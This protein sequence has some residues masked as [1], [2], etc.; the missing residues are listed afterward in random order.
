MVAGPLG[1]T[2]ADID[3]LFGLGWRGI[4]RRGRAASAE[5]RP[6]KHWMG[7]TIVYEFHG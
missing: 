5:I 2:D 7:C 1:L 6:H 3:A 4:Q